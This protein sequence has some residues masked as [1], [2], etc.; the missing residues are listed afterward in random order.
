MS[1][2]ARMDR[3]DARL[4]AVEALAN[5]LEGVLVGIDDQG[6]ITHRMT[7]IAATGHRAINIA[8]AL[9]GELQRMQENI[10]AIVE[11]L[12]S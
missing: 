6:G 5:R 2:A 9:Q 12:N 11:K 8:T 3:M 10:E 1:D 7:E 4:L